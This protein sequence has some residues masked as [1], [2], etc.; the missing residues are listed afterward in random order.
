MESL[1][2]IIKKKKY[3]IDALKLDQ[4]PN[5]KLCVK[6]S[7]NSLESMVSALH[8]STRC[9]MRASLLFR[10]STRRKMRTLNVLQMREKN[11]QE[12]KRRLKLSDWM[13]EASLKLKSISTLQSQ[14]KE[15]VLATT[16][17]LKLA[18]KK[19]W[20]QS[21]TESSSSRCSGN[22]VSSSS[23]LIL[24]A[25]S[26]SM[27]YQIRCLGILAWRITLSS[28]Y[29]SHQRKWMRL[30]TQ[31]K[32]M[33]RKVAKKNFQTWMKKVRLKWTSHLL[34]MFL[35][36]QKP[37]M[38]T[39]SRTKMMKRWKRLMSMTNWTPELPKMTLQAKPKRSHSPQRNLLLRTVSVKPAKK[40]RKKLIEMEK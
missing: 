26:N 4:S 11:L 21:R 14:S 36:I 2:R 12:I 8:A 38:T 19:W 20:T 34:V 25:F 10:R 39:M 17:M 28:S 35:K 30:K 22:V 15:E 37:K 24:I 32:R 13:S 9:Q 5:W 6:R 18:L 31:M 27:S 3:L 23:L 1:I 29:A 7:W 33:A 16:S 40:T